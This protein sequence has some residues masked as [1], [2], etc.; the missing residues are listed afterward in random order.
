MVDR[1]P[2]KS[3]TQGA[4]DKYYSVQ[5]PDTGFGVN[6]SFA[7]L[8]RLEQE[9]NQTFRSL[10]SRGSEMGGLLLGR[11][12]GAGKVI[13]ED[14][15]PVPCGYERGPL[16]WLGDQDRQRLEAALARRNAGGGGSLV[17][18]GY[19]RSNAR[20]RLELDSHDLDVI[21]RYF[22]ARTNVFLLIKPAPGGA[23]VAELFYWRQD[24]ALSQGGVPVALPRTPIGQTPPT[25]AKS[26]QGVLAG[27]GSPSRPS[28]ESSGK[29]DASAERQQEDRP[30]PETLRALVNEAL[31]QHA[32]RS[33]PAGAP[34]ASCGVTQPAAGR[35]L[36]SGGAELG[37]RRKP[38]ARVRFTGR[39]TRR[40]AWSA[41]ITC[42]LVALSGTLG[43]RLVKG[44]AQ[45]E[46]DRPRLALQVEAAGGQLLLKWD[47]TLPVVE[48]AQRGLLTI[49]DGN[50]QR[51]VEMDGPHLRAGSIFY[52][53]SSS[54]VNFRLLIHDPRSGRNLSESVRVVGMHPPTRGS[55][56]GGPA[57]VE[58]PRAAS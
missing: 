5:V 21:G 34:G 56:S 53:P 36:H 8:E 58:F 14:Y 37:P 57:A 49:T 38:A 47:R 50:F 45:A 55:A 28:G 42:L 16:Y 2:I 7:A 3:D 31:Q 15:E 6:I 52:T 18:V 4:G 13:I 29:V 19:F 26:A 27:E 54:D 25:N 51:E 40:R 35:K 22:A 10:N 43:W 46:K 48:A 23:A 9:V 41:V 39:I 20:K 33:Q 30:D 32:R 24:G 17:V 44:T 12:E 11:V 1:H